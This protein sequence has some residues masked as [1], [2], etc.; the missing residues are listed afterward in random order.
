MI[1]ERVYN[2]KIYKLRTPERIKLLE[3]NKVVELSLANTKAEN[4]LDIGTG[5][6][7]FAEA[8]TSK[9]LKV[10]GIDISQEMIEAVR[11]FVPAGEFLTAPAESIPYPDKSF[12]LVFLGH[13]L[14]ETDNPLK[15]L[16]EAKRVAKNRISILEWPYIDEEAG[17]PI[18]HRISLETISELAYKAGLKNIETFQL[19]HMVLTIIDL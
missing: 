5:S 6:G 2:Q 15:A 11:E 8:F 3:I 13:V 19:K 10:N 12:D 9:K 16:R 18:Q 4:V 1:N 14:H 7:I 17:P